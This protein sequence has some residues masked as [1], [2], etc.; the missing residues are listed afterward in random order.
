[1]PK[2]RTDDNLSEDWSDARG[3]DG[4]GSDSDE[5]MDSDSS[6]DNDAADTGKHKKKNKQLNPMKATLGISKKMV[7]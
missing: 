1:V 5:D 7:E 6:D 2:K 3:S 4:S